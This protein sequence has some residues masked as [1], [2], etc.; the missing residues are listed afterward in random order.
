[1]L[2]YGFLA[3][4]NVFQQE[5]RQG[6]MRLPA[7]GAGLGSIFTSEMAAYEREIASLECWSRGESLLDVVYSS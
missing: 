1:M 6:L 7:Q 4:S 5:E 2:K 3:Q